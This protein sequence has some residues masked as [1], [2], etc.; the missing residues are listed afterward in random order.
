MQKDGNEGEI[1]EATV[2]ESKEIVLKEVQF[3]TIEADLVL[4]IED[5]DGIARLN[6]ESETFK[7]DYEL[8]YDN[9]RKFANIRIAV[10]K[11]AK[12]LTDPAN[13]FKKNVKEKTDSILK[14]IA[15][16]ELQFKEDRNVGETHKN[17]IKEEKAQKEAERIAEIQVKVE[18]VRNL[19][20]TLIG[21]KSEALKKELDEEFE[22]FT[23]QMKTVS[24][25]TNQ[26]LVEMYD[27][28]WTREKKEAELKAKHEAETKEKDRLRKEQEE[29]D[30]AQAE[31]L[32]QLKKEKAE[33]DAKLK[34]IEDEKKAEALKV[35]RAE[36]KKKYEADEIVT[37]QKNKEKKETDEKAQKEAEEKWRKETIK[38]IEEHIVNPK[39]FVTAEHVLSAIEEGKISHVEYRD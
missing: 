24:L 6:V 39:N 4:A 2:E 33:S 37:R 10:T 31:E 12:S 14:I 34:A 28:A 18:T 15:P 9:E 23:E 26:K 1:V 19:P 25:A 8:A 27:E 20:L 36:Q 29:K 11:H 7:D 22:E 21:A 35:E 38:D 13:L 3:K 16:Y 17:K 5:A 30:K 32:A